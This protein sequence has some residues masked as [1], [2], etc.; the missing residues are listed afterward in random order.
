MDICPPNSKLCAKPKLMDS[1]DK[2]L[3]ESVLRHL[4]E[5]SDIDGIRFGP[6]LQ[7]LITDHASDKEPIHGQVY[8]NLGSAWK[9]FVARPDSFPDGEGDLPGVT[10]EEQI[11]TICSLRERTIVRV[12]LGKH[13]PHLILTLDDGR[14]VFINGKHEAYECLDMGVAF[15]G[16]GGLVVA[17]P[18][19]DVAVWA[20]S[21]FAQSGA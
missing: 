12:E 3:A 21:K 9:V 20:P 18:G 5:G 10:P 15:G 4:C 1:K 16:G 11:Q 17:C 19:G 14:V 7:I 6:A 2:Q 13:Q 8:L